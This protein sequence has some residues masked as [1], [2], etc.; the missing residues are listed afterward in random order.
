MESWWRWSEEG[1]GVNAE[2]TGGSLR[3]WMNQG[4]DSGNGGKF[5]VDRCG[6]E[7]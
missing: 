6:C 4:G 1:S 2:T 3:G 5:T 7:S